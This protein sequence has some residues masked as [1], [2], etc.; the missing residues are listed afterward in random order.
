[1]AATHGKR[2]RIKV[3]GAAVVFTNEATTDAGD[4]KSYQITATAKQVW[5][6]QAAIT[7]QRSTDGGATWGAA[8][9]AYTL[10]RLKGTIT[11]TSAN[12]AADKIR[13]SGS[14]LPLTTAAAAKQF[15]YSAK[16]ATVEATAFGDV[17]LTRLQATQDC[18]GSLALWWL[19]SYFATALDAGLPIVVEQ[20]I[21]DGA[22]PAFRAWA[23]LTER[24]LQ[25][26]QGGLLEEPIT[27]EGAADADNTSFT[28][29][30]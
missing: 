4:H 8:V 29:L 25:V 7:V 27:W 12:G 2:V 18:A 3:S 28:F 5:D 24:G 10:N 22:T 26:V 16:A 21:A 6:P 20:S 15:S 13:V 9:G 17:D 11:F 19:D 14:Y 23:L 1:M 30:V